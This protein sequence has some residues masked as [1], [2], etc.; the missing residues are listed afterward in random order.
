MQNLDQNFADFE[1]NSRHLEKNK[2]FE[3]LQSNEEYSRHPEN[4]E[5]DQNLKNSRHLENLNNFENFEN[6]A[7]TV[8]HLEQRANL[9]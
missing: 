7:K 1:Q 3:D 8:R 2:L 9:W 4:E 5:Y 6:F